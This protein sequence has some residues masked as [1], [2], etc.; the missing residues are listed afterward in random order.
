MFR[1]RKM[2]V[3]YLQRRRSIFVFRDAETDLKSGNR[4]NLTFRQSQF[5]N[6]EHNPST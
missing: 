6:E 5:Y 2:L 4:G 1:W 3:F